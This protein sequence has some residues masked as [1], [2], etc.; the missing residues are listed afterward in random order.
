MSPHPGVAQVKTRVNTSR[1]V[2][3]SEECNDILM[4]P[5]WVPE[6]PAPGVVQVGPE[7]RGPGDVPMGT[8]VTRSGEAMLRIRVTTYRCGPGGARVTWY[9]RVQSQDQSYKD[10][11]VPGGIE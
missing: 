3:D 11:A 9:R 5:R 2:T 8:T 6:T 7:T 1:C 4:L 10:Q